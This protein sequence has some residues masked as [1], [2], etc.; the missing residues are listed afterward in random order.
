M[1]HRQS[2]WCSLMALE[3]EIYRFDGPCMWCLCRSPSSALY[4][5]ESR[6][7]EERTRVG[8]CFAGHCIVLTSHIF[9]SCALDILL[10]Q[11]RIP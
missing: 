10:K 4:T 6:T 9:G 11:R 1:R 7:S 8:S 5:K 2:C 3:S